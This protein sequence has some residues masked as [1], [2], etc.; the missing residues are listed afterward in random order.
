MG[1]DFPGDA[2]VVGRV[3]GVILRVLQLKRVDYQHGEVEDEE[4]G[5]ERA[6]RLVH[7]LVNRARLS[8]RGL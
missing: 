4:E 1:D 3:N 8:P 5:D 2:L 6:S 7:H